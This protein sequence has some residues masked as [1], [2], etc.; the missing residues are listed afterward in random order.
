[1]NREQIEALNYW[2]ALRL[3]QNTEWNVN[4]AG[5][6]L[7]QDEAVKYTLDT[8]DEGRSFRVGEWEPGKNTG[9]IVRTIPAP[10]EIEF[11]FSLRWED[12]DEE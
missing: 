2:D 9:L 4:H 6:I 5:W 8:L 11:L 12:E 1:M 7:H 10:P 3:A